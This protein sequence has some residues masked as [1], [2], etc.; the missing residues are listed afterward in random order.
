MILEVYI[1][2][3]NIYLILKR[4]SVLIRF[5]LCLYLDKTESI[6]EHSV[7][8]LQSKLLADGTNGDYAADSYHLYK[9][10]V[11]CLRQAGVR[12]SIRLCE[13]NHSYIF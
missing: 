10:D 6:Y 13:E 7:H 5:F 12:F 9:D 2:W 1:V 3:A 4:E 11:Q 8:K